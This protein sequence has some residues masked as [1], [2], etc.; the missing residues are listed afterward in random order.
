MTRIEANLKKNE[1]IRLTLEGME[2]FPI[3]FTYDQ[4]LEVAASRVSN[5][6]RMR[7]NQLARALHGVVPETPHE[8]FADDPPT[9]T[10][11]LIQ[12]VNKH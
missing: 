9:A 6:A 12:K 11:V 10:G 8:M 4:M 2:S 7:Q 5:E 1:I 3:E